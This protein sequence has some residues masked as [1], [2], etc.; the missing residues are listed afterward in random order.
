V[1]G[2]E[3]K[4][5]LGTFD[6]LENAIENTFPKDKWEQR[7]NYARFKAAWAHRIVQHITLEDI[8]D[9][10]KKRLEALGQFIRQRK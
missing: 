9:G 2:Q 3:V 1:T 5:K 10:L 8:S 7:W 6:K 4:I